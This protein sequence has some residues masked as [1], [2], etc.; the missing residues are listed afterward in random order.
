M[1]AS[2][3]GKRARSMLRSIKIT[4][5]GSGRWSASATRTRSATP[6]A[7]E[8]ESP[9]LYSTA[10]P[11][12][13]APRSLLYEGCLLLRGRFDAGTDF[14][15]TRMTGERISVLCNSCTEYTSKLRCP[16]GALRCL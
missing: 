9:Y 6:G 3:K 2:A 5:A 10:A 4:F 14:S 7:Q 11:K 15:L 8:G 12:A 16:D 1:S 13:L